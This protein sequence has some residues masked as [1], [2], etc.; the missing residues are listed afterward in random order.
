[1]L[2]SIVMF[3]ESSTINFIQPQLHIYCT[4]FEE[5]ERE[6]EGERE[7]EVHD[8]EG[9]YMHGF[10]RSPGEP[11]YPMS[12]RSSTPVRSVDFCGHDRNEI[13]SSYKFGRF[14]QLQDYHPSNMT[15]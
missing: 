6:R 13:L 2:I 9:A 8:H 10:C 11:L 1:M 12:T 15:K 4:F 3:L 14:R 5:R 7:R